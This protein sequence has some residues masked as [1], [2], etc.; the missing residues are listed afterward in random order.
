MANTAR[1]IFEREYLLLRG[2]LIE[3]AAV[4]DR[5]ARAEGTVDNDP[6]MQQIRQALQALADSDGEDRRAERLLML[7]SL[8][9][10]P[11]WRAH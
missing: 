7:F 3:V 4:L 5:V 9:Y 11:Q 1:E 6:R 2:K 10:D 8:P